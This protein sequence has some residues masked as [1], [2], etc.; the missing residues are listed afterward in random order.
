MNRLNKIGRTGKVRARP[1][2]VLRGFLVLFSAS[3]LIGA[4][5]SP[6]RG[7]SVSDTR[8]VDRF[9]SPV[10]YTR[11]PSWMPV[12]QF[13]ENVALR[14][15]HKPVPTTQAKPTP[16]LTKL[17]FAAH[18]NFERLVLDFSDRL[19]FWYWTMPQG[20]TLTLEFPDLAAFDGHRLRKLKSKLMTDTR[21]TAN[22]NGRG[23]RFAIGLSEKSR[24]KRIFLLPPDK[25]AGHRLVVDIVGVMPKVVPSRG[26][27][28]AWG[29]GEK[30]D[31]IGPTMLAK[32]YGDAGTA[33]AKATIS[34]SS[35]KQVDEDTRHLDVTNA[36]A[37][38]PAFDPL[39]PE[40]VD[41]KTWQKRAARLSD[42]L[43]K[44]I[45][46]HDRIRAAQSDVDAAHESLL[47]TRKTGTPTLDITAFYGHE[48]QNKG[49]G[50][51]NTNLV[52]REMDFKLTHL[53]TDFGATEALE[54]QAELALAQAR[55]IRDATVQAIVLEGLAAHYQLAGA[56][57]TLRYA[58]LSEQNIKRQTNLEDARVKRGAGLVTDALQAKAQLAGASALR[59]RAEG[60]MA[61]AR[62]RYQSVFGGLPASTRSAVALPVPD[63]KLPAS[64]AAGVDVALEKSHQLEVGRLLSEIARVETQRLKSSG[65]YPTLNLI[66]ESKWKNDAAGTIGHQD[67]QIIRFEMTFPFKPGG[68]ATDQVNASK[69]AYLASSQRLADARLQVREKVQVAWQQLRTARQVADQLRNQAELAAEFLG[70]ARKERK[71]GKRSLIDVLSGEVAL[72]N[73]RANAV[74]AENSLALA[75]WT[76]LSTMGTLDP[77]SII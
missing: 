25:S 13:A 61:S 55:V 3:A 34:T 50:V 48:R 15:D 4:S 29:G 62:F 69:Q 19:D 16:S 63:E 35:T 24:L 73:A 2:G 40:R 41:D 71:L 70:L 45:T 52:T 67:E 72:A 9:G 28:M 1:K 66:A 8:F 21:F 53:L 5:W 32:L 23:G 36:V 27:G 54:E 33:V 76:L 42:A 46:R 64:L 11:L 65:Y 30:L 39:W 68:A 49:Q 10:V 44:L 56:R 6:L 22:S 60:A 77:E 31:H 51:A 18:K 74:A 57:Q 12:P 59:V 7:P 75:A 38:G 43:R 47:A 14:P 58:R 37:T 26:T 17:R 20:D